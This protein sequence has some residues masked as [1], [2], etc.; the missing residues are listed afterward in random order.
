MRS[1]AWVAAALVLLGAVPARKEAPAPIRVELSPVAH[2]EPGLEP[3]VRQMLLKVARDPKNWPA[4]MKGEGR[5]EILLRL[6][7]GV[8]LDQANRGGWTPVKPRP[9]EKRD[10]TGPWRLFQRTV[11]AGRV[12]ESPDLL[13][14]EVIPLRIVED[15][16]NWVITARVRLIQGGTTIQAFGAIFASRQRGAAELHALPKGSL[17][18]IFRA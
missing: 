1:L 13:A 3:A 17:S 16:T 10:A 15:G 4:D 18:P 12:K 7:I 11:P 14:R 8:D 9:E 6:P 2:P 5:L